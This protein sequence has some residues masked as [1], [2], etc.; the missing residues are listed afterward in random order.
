MLLADAF[1]SAVCSLMLFCGLLGIALKYF[2]QK[3]DSKGEIKEA[4]KNKIVS[5]IRDYLK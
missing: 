2:F 4:A 5:K 3:V 1:G